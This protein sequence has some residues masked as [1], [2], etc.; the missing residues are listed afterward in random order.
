MSTYESR[1]HDVQ[2]RTPLKLDAFTYFVFLTSLFC[3]VLQSNVLHK[4]PGKDL[5]A[6]RTSHDSPYE[7]GHTHVLTVLIDTPPCVPDDLPLGIGQRLDALR[8]LLVLHLSSSHSQQRRRRGWRWRLPARHPPAA[9]Q[10]GGSQQGPG[11]VGSEGGGEGDGELRPHGGN[12]ERRVRVRRGAERRGE[13]RG[14]R[15]RGGSWRSQPKIRKH[16]KKN[17]PLNHP[18]SDCHSY[19]LTIPNS[20]SLS[21]LLLYLKTYFSTPLRSLL[22]LCSFSLSPVSSPLPSSLSLSPPTREML[23]GSCGCF[24]PSP[25]LSL[26]SLSDS[27]APVKEMRRLRL[28]CVL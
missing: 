14:G 7:H 15:G 24:P 4:D 2:H 16:S 22:R 1:R 10:L 18:P 8:P 9:Q 26:L 17:K 6:L 5:G 19:F 20:A 28:W 25:P 23:G 21:L 3:S 13:R 27:L 12:W 11:E